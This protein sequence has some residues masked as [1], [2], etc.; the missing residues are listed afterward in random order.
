MKRINSDIDLTKKILIKV[1]GKIF[2][3]VLMSKMY[4]HIDPLNGEIELGITSK[5]AGHT[6]VE[7]NFEENGYQSQNTHKSYSEEV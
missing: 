5:Y 4:I 3:I 7:L 1:L 6:P 2:I